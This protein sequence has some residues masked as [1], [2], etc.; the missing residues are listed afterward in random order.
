V[1]VRAVDSLATYETVLSQDRSLPSVI[2]R[3]SAHSHATAQILLRLL[4]DARAR[5]CHSWGDLQR[6][7]GA[8][9]RRAS[10]S[11]GAPFPQPK[12]TTA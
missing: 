8:R 11:I 6:L 7:L 1:V 10:R 9:S 2:T 12:D 5:E 4:A 3:A